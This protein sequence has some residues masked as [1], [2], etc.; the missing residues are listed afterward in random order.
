MDKTFTISVRSKQAKNL[1]KIPYVCGNADYRVAFDF[2][3][4]WNQYPIKTARFVTADGT[5]YE[6]TVIDNQ[7]KFPQIM[8]TFRAD[9]GVYAGDLVTTT[10]AVVE[11]LRS[12]RSGTGATPEVPEPDRYDQMMEAINADALR[13]EEAA[14]AAEEKLENMQER[15]YTPNVDEDGNLTWAPNADD[16]PDLP[17]VNIKGLKAR[18]KSLLCADLAATALTKP[19]QKS[20][21]PSS[22]TLLCCL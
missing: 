21:P 4:D 7:C 14:N 22:K 13:A 11:C 18:R 9:V 16:M 20:K 2:D 19:T 5:P 6:E 8:D 1:S 17:P 10:P 15:Y 3:D 12:I